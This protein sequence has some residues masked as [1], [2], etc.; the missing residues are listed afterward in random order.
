MIPNPVNYI[1]TRTSEENNF[2]CLSTVPQQRWNWANDEQGSS[3]AKGCSKLM[4]NINTRCFIAGAQRFSFEVVDF[5]GTVSV[6]HH[7]S[8]VYWTP[9]E[10]KNHGHIKAPGI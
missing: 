9:D 3:A 6:G 7:Y 4:S 10:G 2:G 1:Q 5:P 8:D